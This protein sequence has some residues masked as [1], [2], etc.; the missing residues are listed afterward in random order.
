MLKNTY[1][2]DV[3]TDFNGLAKL[4]TDAKQQTPGAIKEVAKQFESVFV[5]M[6][7]KSMRDAK[8]T[9]GGIMDNDQSRFF[10]DMY[11]QQLAVHLSGEP[12]I[13]L[14]DMI[15]KQL[16]AKEED[17]KAELAGLGLPEY[18]DEPL[19]LYNYDET[20]LSS[21]IPT[22]Q[23]NTKLDFVNQLGDSAKEAAKVLGVDAK[24]LLAQAALETGW[25]KK[26]LKSS[27]GNP[28]FNLFNIKAYNNWHG[29]KVTV[30]TLEFNQGVARK[31][32]AAFRAYDSYQ[33]SFND[34]VEFIK[35]NP[36]YK[37]ALASSANVEEYIRELQSAGYATDPDYAKKVMRIYRDDAFNSL[38]DVA[39]IAGRYKE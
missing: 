5:G 28:S 24:V 3:Y 35:Y 22:S 18:Q 14:A 30:N 11:D 8:L 4:K 29:K 32:K 31:E 25:G 21:Y 9:E 16:G 19:K 34:Y 17:A 15:A 26:V 20:L 10:Q 38:D 33:E 37:H 7:L 36:R 13:G 39:S 1:S 27:N 12:G 23:M 2:A 6:V